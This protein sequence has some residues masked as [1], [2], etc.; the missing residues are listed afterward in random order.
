M[1]T[2]KPRSL[3]ALRR[4]AAMSARWRGH[5]LRWSQPF[6]RADGPQSQIGRCRCGMEVIVHQ[7]PAP[8]QIDIGGEAV[9][10]GCPLKKAR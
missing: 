6:G 4:E 2:P 10:V 3:N 1:K 5:S 7:R 8:N 9:A